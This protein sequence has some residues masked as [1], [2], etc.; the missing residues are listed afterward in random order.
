VFLYILIRKE[1]PQKDIMYIVEV[2]V[3]QLCEFVDVFLKYVRL[4][5]CRKNPEKTE[6]ESFLFFPNCSLEQAQEI[7]SAGY[8]V[9]EEK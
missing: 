6:N 3:S 4:E 1:S 8:I 5:N 2:H 9:F 7:D